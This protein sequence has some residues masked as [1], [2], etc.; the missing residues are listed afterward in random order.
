MEHF[1][2]KTVKRLDLLQVFESNHVGKWTGLQ[3]RG[4]C[5]TTDPYNLYLK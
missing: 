1:M 4:R 3:Y 2:R 5:P